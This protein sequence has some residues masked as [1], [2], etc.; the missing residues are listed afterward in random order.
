MFK[1]CV[2]SI[3]VPVFAVSDASGVTAPYGTLGI[4][5]I[6][7]WYLWYDTTITK[8]AIRKEMRDIISVFTEELQANRADFQSVLSRLKD[9]NHDVDKNS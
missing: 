4:F 9:E 6:L 7:A 5:A 8:P 2:V 1:L 3:V